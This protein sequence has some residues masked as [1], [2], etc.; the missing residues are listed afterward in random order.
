[1][2]LPWLRLAPALDLLAEFS[3]ACDLDLEALGTSAAAD[4]LNQTAVAQPLLVASALLSYRLSHSPPANLVAGHSVGMITAFAIAGAYDDATAV[5]LAAA[6]G[7][8]FQTATYQL[9]S[10]AI[11]KLDSSYDD[12]LDSGD[13]DSGLPQPRYAGTASMIALIG[14]SVLDKFQT[15]HWA[16]GLAVQLAVVNSPTQIVV[17]GTSSALTNLLTRLPAG[18]KAIPLQVNGAFHTEFMAPAVAPL[19]AVLEQIEINDT[20]IQL[21]N[22]LTGQPFTGG[23]NGFGTAANVR[24]HLLAQVTTPVRWDLVTTWLK[25]LVNPDADNLEVTELT[26]AGTLTTILKR[27]ISSATFTPLGKSNYVS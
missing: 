5:R 18:I 8:N 26:P 4:Q 25:N 11:D 10:G 1:M 27:E 22:D 19:A 16:D 2:L 20:Q 21:L 12:K 24:N 15:E 6:R 17:G 13:N 9:E 7:R 14:K 3:A 23:R